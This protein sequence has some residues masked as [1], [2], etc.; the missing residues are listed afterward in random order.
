[1][2]MYKNHSSISDNAMNVEFEFG[3]VASLVLILKVVLLWLNAVE[4]VSTG[5]IIT[6][7]ILI[8]LYIVE[9]F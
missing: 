5:I 3:I 1:M 6:F 4:E 7:I 8:I 2:A 9:Y